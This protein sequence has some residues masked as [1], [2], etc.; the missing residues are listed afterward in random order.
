MASKK[1]ARAYL[2]DFGEA[3]LLDVDVLT[4]DQIL[5]VLDTDGESDPFVTPWKRASRVAMRSAFVY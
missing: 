4:A 1:A 5:A 3:S 2:G